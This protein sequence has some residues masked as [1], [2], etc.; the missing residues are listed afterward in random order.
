[1]VKTVLLACIVIAAAA[2]ADRRVIV[3]PAGPKPVGPYSP[4]IL[5]GDYLYV[6]GQGSRTPDGRELGSFEERARQCLENVK[7]IVEA[8]GLTMEHVVYAHLYLDNLANLG[9]ADRVWR[10]YFGKNPPARAVVGVKRMPTD[11]PIEITVVA[12]RDLAHKKVVELPRGEGRAVLT[13][14]RL[15][16]ASVHGRDLATGK[17]PADP[18]EEVRTA[19]E[20]AEKV[21]KA[22]GLSLAHMVF[23]NP[24]L[25]AAMP[26]E[27]MNRLYARYF[28]FGNTPARATLRMN[29]LPGRRQLRVHRRGREGIWP[30]GAPC[31][32]RTWRPARR[33]AP[34]SLPATRCIARPSRLHPRTAQR[35]LGAGRR[36][37][38]APDMRNLLD[39]LEEAGMDFSHVVATN[40]YVDD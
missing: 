22:A 12:V 35:H 18:A 14:D 39:G 29:E 38:G 23:I 7:A 5:V 15:Y 28:E 36:A 20:R 32:R 33:P 17:P 30:S 13:H 11:T 26:M 27:V 6:S 10:T 37:S 2:G 19:L 16:L 8:A 31:G 21:L 25:T 9:V 40:V 1:M 3:P 4:G 24:Y 34:A